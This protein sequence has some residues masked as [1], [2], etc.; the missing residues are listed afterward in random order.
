LKAKSFQGAHYP[1]L[2][3]ELLIWIRRMDTK[4]ACLT[5]DVI[6]EQARAM[7]ALL[8]TAQNCRVPIAD[9]WPQSGTEGG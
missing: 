6:V 8:D 3:H 1:E 5:D 9:A 4:Q 7:L 2:E